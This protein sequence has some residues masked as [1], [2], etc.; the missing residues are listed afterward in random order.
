MKCKSGWA[1]AAGVICVCLATAAWAGGK[2]KIGKG[3]RDPKWFACTHV[4]D[5]TV[6][7][8]LC[9][10][11]TG[12]NVRHLKAYGRWVQ[13][14]QVRIRCRGGIQISHRAVV[15]CEEST[16]MASKAPATK[17]GQ[18]RAG[19][20]GECTSLSD[21]VVSHSVCG[22]PV[23]IPAT[24]RKAWERTVRRRAKVADCPGP[25]SRSQRAVLACEK[26]RCVGGPAP[27]KPVN[28]PGPVQETGGKGQ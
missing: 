15:A 2:K 27:G 20:E 13:D 4:S 23:G 28:P 22:Q 10:S 9:G 16:C 12:V 18:L 19:V 21:C 1:L 11:P 6:A 14:R 25:V 7:E 3:E 24:K 17:A 5:C 8:G 26:N